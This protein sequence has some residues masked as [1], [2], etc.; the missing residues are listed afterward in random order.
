MAL[1]TSE[2]LSNQTSVLHPRVQCRLSSRLTAP[3]TSELLSNQTS[4]LHPRVQCRLSSRLTALITSELLSNQLMGENVLGRASRG[5]HWE[6]RI[7]N[8]EFMAYV[9]A[10]CKRN[11]RDDAA[12]SD[13]PA[14]P[15]LWSRS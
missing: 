14:L 1:I 11:Q 7:M 10:E 3:I 12:L 13:L 6:T 4:V 5:S 2:M 9:S 15:S 8:D